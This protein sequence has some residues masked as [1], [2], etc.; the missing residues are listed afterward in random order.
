MILYI[1]DVCGPTDAQG[2]QQQLQALPGQLS[3][4]GPAAATASSAAVLTDG[5][6]FI[7][8]DLAGLVPAVAAGELLA[9][10]AG[11]GVK[12]PHTP[13]QVCIEG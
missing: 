2:R 3:G 6:G 1:P 12:W 4:G 7:S 5:S 8:A 10:H 11:Q 13:L 9:A